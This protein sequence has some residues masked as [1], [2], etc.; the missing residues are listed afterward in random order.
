MGPIQKQ[1]FGAFPISIVS[2][3]HSADATH[4]SAWA[5]QSRRHFEACQWCRPQ[6]QQE[7]TEPLMKFLGEFFYMMSPQANLNTM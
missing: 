2:P 1:F 4:E 3:V 5:A 7:A 6:E